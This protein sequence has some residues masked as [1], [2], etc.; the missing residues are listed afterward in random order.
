MTAATLRQGVKDGTDPKILKAKLLLIRTAP[1]EIL[2]VGPCSSDDAPDGSPRDVELMN[3]SLSSDMPGTGAHR[4]VSAA[5]RKPCASHY[6]SDGK[7]NHIPL[8]LTH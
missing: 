1:Y 6:D 5:S 8:G 4:R 2:A 3:L 7:P